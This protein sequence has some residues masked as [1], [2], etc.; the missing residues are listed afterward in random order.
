VD[1]IGDEEGPLARAVIGKHE[2]ALALTREKVRLTWHP[3]D[4]TLACNGET[5]VKGVPAKILKSM[6]QAYISEGRV[7]FEYRE[8]KRDFDISLGQ[9][10]SNFEVRFYRL[11]ERLQEKCPSLAIAK[12]GRGRFELHVGCELSLEG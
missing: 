3:G 12:A 10:N 8:F 2:S 9:K 11:I 5:L 6:V 1:D 4:E 7:S